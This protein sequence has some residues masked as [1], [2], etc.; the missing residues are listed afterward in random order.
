MPTAAEAKKYLPTCG[1]GGELASR[2]GGTVA[3]RIASDGKNIVA[4]RSAKGLEDQWPPKTPTAK[5]AISLREMKA[6][7]PNDEALSII[8]RPLAGSPLAEREGYFFLAA[9]AANDEETFRGAKGD[10]VLANEG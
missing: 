1:G 8:D 2:R 5:V 4:F 6:N 3:C 9:N 7:P 10:N